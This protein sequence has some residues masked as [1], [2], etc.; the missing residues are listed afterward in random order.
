[1]DLLL[2]QREFFINKETLKT[3]KMEYSQ[4][5]TPLSNMQIELLKL[6]T[7]DLEES[8]LIALKRIMVKYLSEKV[9]NLADNIWKDKNWTER[10]M[11]NLLNKHDRTSY[12]PE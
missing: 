5:S 2:F 1:M 6:F 10:D 8:D 3:D 7:H 12:K 4:L 11:D 9:S